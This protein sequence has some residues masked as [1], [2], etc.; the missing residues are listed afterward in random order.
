MPAFP[1]MGHLPR[2]FTLK[3]E[4]YQIKD[5]SRKDVR[6]LLRLDAAQGRPVAARA[7]IA[8][9]GTSRSSGPATTAKGASSTTAWAIVREVWD[10]P[11]IQKMWLEMVPWSMG[12]IPGDARPRPLTGTGPRG[13]RGR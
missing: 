2:S 11:D 10:R 7:S 4:I 9:T 12:L 8:R 13:S 6:V 5:F 1:G 3:D